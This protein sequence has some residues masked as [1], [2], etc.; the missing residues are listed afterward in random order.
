[1]KLKRKINLTKGKENNKK[2]SK[3]KL[4]NNKSQIRMKTEIENK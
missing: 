4:E 2:K 1:M 3:I